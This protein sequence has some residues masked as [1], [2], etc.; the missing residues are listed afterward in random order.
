MTRQLSTIARFSFAS[1]SFAI[2]AAMATDANADTYSHI[3][4]I[5]SRIQKR[6]NQIV[7][8]TSH[9]VHTP[10]Y[11][12]LRSD[13]I[14]VAALAE[15][16]H[17]LAH[18]HGSVAHLASDLAELD[19]EFHHM[20]SLFHQIEISAAHGHG[21]VHGN[22]AHARR[23]LD[24]IEDDIHHLQT[25]IASLRVVRHRP[26]IIAPAPV[27][28]IPQTYGGHGCS[29]GSRAITIG[30]SSSRITFRF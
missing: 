2:I 8:E 15:H 4:Q 16:I 24:R 11:A 21:H 13:A 23:L 19:A 14:A 7:N 25:D 9:Y 26:V 22:T 27:Y 29:S 5:A 3:D 30:G 10:Q 18:H 12:H 6:A 17:E 1:F 28:R 20:E